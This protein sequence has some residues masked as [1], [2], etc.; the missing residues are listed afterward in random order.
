MVCAVRVFGEVR[1][2]ISVDGRVKVKV[3]VNF[4]GGGRGARPTWTGVGYECFWRGAGELGGA[5]EVIQIKSKIIH[6]DDGVRPLRYVGECFQQATWRVGRD[7][8]YGKGHT[9]RVRHGE[10]LWGQPAL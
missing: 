5:G 1:V 10:A 2:K 9:E 3:N 6:L 7:D 8:V 4:K